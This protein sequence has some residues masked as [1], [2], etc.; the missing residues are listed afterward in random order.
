MSSSVIPKTINK[1]TYDLIEKN[2]N[3]VKYQGKLFSSYV[4]NQ[5][6]I[7]ITAKCDFI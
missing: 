6:A 5:I 2:N 7:I 4:N 3:I 1:R